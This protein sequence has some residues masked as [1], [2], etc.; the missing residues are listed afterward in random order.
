MATRPVKTQSKKKRLTSAEVAR[1]QGL[2]RERLLTDLLKATPG[3]PIAGQRSLSEQ[4]D[5][6]LSVVRSTLADLKKE[7]II[8]SVPRGGMRLAAK[9]ELPKSLVGVKVAFVGYMEEENPMSKQSRPAVICAGLERILNAQGG[10]LQFLNRWSV[11]NFQSIVEEIKQRKTEAILYNGSLHTSA[12]DELQALA[13]L[14]LPLVAI[15]QET[16]VCDSVAF[17]NRQI[18]QTV[19]AHLLDLGHRNVCILEFPEHE[20]SNSRVQGIRDEFRKR[21]VKAP[22]AYGLSYPPEA[23]EI[24]AFVRAKG[25]SYSACIAVNDHIGR[26]MLAA[27]R[28][29]E[30]RVP[31][32]LSIIGADDRFDYRHLNLTTVQLFDME[33]GLAA[34]KIL[35]ERL[36][37]PE[38]ERKSKAHLL[39]CPL[40]VRETTAQY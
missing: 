2:C 26:M 12:A 39:A 28:E 37:E 18:G 8:A 35:K 31:E 30:I 29:Q 32:E 33:L 38:A 40:I 9:P 10:T 21:G 7:G 34:F 25:R 19:A 14:G 16:M 11:D 24:Q 3:A 17:D 27:A 23:D 4:Y 13:E 36:L 5:I 22:D 1:L 15:E 20:W 6:S